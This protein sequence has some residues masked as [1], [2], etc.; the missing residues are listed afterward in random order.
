MNATKT[1][2][3]CKK[4]ERTHRSFINQEQPIMEVSKWLDVRVRLVSL[5]T[6]LVAA[7]LAVA[8]PNSATA[9]P[10]VAAFAEAEPKVATGQVYSQCLL[11]WHDSIQVHSTRVVVK[12]NHQAVKTRMKKLEHCIR[13][14]VTGPVDVQGMAKG[15]V[16]KCVNYGLNHNKTRHIVEGIVAIV[17]DVYGTGGAAIS[18]KLADYIKSVGDNT[19][20]C[21]S[22]GDQI[23]EFFATKLKQEFDARVSKESHW[24][25]WDL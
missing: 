9:S 24:V 3:T 13:I 5:S 1:L 11:R 12:W 17:S 20:D 7:T 4:T 22:D 6:M 16:K 21:L 18:A 15:Y 10:F 23:S 8:S 2:I 25:Y 14:N 19:L